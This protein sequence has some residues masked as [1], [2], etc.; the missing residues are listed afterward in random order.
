MLTANPIGSL[1]KLNEER[2]TQ[3]RQCK[4]N[5]SN[6]RL[7][8]MFIPY[9]ATNL[10]H[11]HSY[12]CR[13]VIVSIEGTRNRYE[14]DI[15]IGELQ[16][17]VASSLV[18]PDQCTYILFCPSKAFSFLPTATIVNAWCWIK[19]SMQICFVHRRFQLIG[20]Q[21]QIFECVFTYHFTTDRWTVGSGTNHWTIS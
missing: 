9:D 2:I 12:G 13:D 3:F 6:W 15:Y 16:W 8:I 5:I 14:S 19:C 7:R 1:N 18:Q 17:S 4:L 20:V 10:W 11:W 21:Q